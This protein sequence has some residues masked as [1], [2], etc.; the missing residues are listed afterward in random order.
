[1]QPWL[2]KPTQ[3]VRLDGLP[4]L[5]WCKAQ[6]AHNCVKVCIALLRPTSVGAFAHNISAAASSLVAQRLP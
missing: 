4:G 2:A 6:R 1:M 5:V 3:L